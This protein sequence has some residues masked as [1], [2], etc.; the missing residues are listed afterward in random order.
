MEINFHAKRIHSNALSAGGFF[1]VWTLTTDALFTKTQ[2][3][4]V[5]ERKSKLQS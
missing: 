4:T 5:V 1:A 3:Q 2:K